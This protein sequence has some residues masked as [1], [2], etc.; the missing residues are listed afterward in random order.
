MGQLL[1]TMKATLATLG[2][3]FDALG[4]QAARVAGLGQAAET[5]QQINELREQLQERGRVQ[6][7]RIDEIREMLHGVLLGDDIARHVKHEVE[8]EIQRRVKLRVSEILRRQA[9]DR[10]SPI[11]EQARENQTQLFGLQTGL[12]NSDARRSNSAIAS[13]QLSSPLT[14]IVRADGQ[15]PLNFPKDMPELLGQSAESARQLLEHYEIPCTP[16]E[17]REM[18]L[19]RFMSHIGVGF[20]MVPVPAKHPPLVLKI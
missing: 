12:K 15:L 5:S 6:E 10:I 1:A 2:S 18:H 7:R 3:T 19:N 20:H 17:S 16:Q 9:E 11:L 8:R 4:E 13:H 14:P